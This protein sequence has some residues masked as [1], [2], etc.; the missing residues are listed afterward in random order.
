M[1]NI[2]KIISLLLVFAFALSLITTVF[3]R[4]RFEAL[5]E[6]IL[7]QADFEA[8]AKEVLALAEA[9]V[10]QEQ[11][12][13]IE[14]RWAEEEAF[15]ANLTPESLWEAWLSE[16]P[17]AL[18]LRTNG[19]ELLEAR[20]QVEALYESIMSTGNFAAFSG[21]LENRS[22]ELAR[23]FSSHDGLSIVARTAIELAGA[24]SLG[25]AM[26]VFPGAANYW[27][28]DAFR[29]YRWNFVSVSALPVGITQAGRYSSTR[30]YTTNYELSR[31]VLRHM[32]ALITSPN[33]TAH[34]IATAINLRQ[35]IF[36]ASFADWQ[37]FFDIDCSANGHAL[38]D[39]MDLYN[40]YRGRQDGIGAGMFTNHL[41][42]FNNRWN[43]GRLVRNLDE[44]RNRKPDV[45]FGG[46]D[47][48]F[49]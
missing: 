24:E 22:R 28:Q 36:N 7:T 43:S 21:F 18:L 44:A 20:L 27:R 16:N 47:F 6:Q 26:I 13:A 12:D 4:E 31:T 42:E 17:E 8:R 34:Q 9:A 29:H 19:S 23:E 46:M 40:N 37:W 3:A 11:V 49:N 14:A 15:F 45:F 30:I 5:D 33:L 2:K 10:T 41:V 39:I 35:F 32:P 25:E 48:P 38:N 1:R